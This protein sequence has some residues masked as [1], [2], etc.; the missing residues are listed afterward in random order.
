VRCEK[1]TQISE[2]KQG[3][4]TGKSGGNATSFSLLKEKKKMRERPI[5]GFLKNATGE[6]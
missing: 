3:L 2:K 1:K 6:S 5:S 4:I